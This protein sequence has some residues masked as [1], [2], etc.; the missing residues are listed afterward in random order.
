MG[1]VWLEHYFGNF[2]ELFG[3]LDFK[4]VEFMR[5]L[6]FVRIFDFPDFVFYCFEESELSLGEWVRFPDHSLLTKIF[7]W[8]ASVMIFFLWASFNAIQSNIYVLQACL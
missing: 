2:A 8:I 7:I 3:V 5:N 6:I 1:T 4:R